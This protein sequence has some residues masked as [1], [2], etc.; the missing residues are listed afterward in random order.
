MKSGH[1]TDQGSVQGIEV[2]VEDSNVVVYCEGKV[3][4]PEGI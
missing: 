1:I 2:K 3:P 4:R